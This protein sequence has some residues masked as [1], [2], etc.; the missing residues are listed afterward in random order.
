M[1]Q[2]QSQATTGGRTLGDAGQPGEGQEQR[3][4]QQQQQTE[5]TLDERAR[6]AQVLQ[7]PFSRRLFSAGSPK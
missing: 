2:G 4:Q 7:L 1:G 3:Q 5:I 6:L